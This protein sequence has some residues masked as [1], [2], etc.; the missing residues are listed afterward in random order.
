MPVDLRLMRYVIAVADEGGFERAA[1]RLHMA[2][3]PLSRQIRQL[4]HDLGVPLFTRR[5]TRPT[6]AGELF[7]DRARGIL[8]QVDQL[9]EATR[10][11]GAAETG[12]VRVGHT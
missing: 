2:Q 6:E 5:P 12:T 10:W 1:R 3:P 9:V 8:A 7:V 11:A 4:E